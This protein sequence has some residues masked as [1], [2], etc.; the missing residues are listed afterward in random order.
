VV[1][2]IVEPSHVSLDEQAQ[3]AVCVRQMLM[4]CIRD[5]RPR[6]EIGQIKVPNLGSAGG[7]RPPPRGY[8]DSAMR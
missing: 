6:T 1:K 4:S 7:E 5:A 3:A 2:T 8:D